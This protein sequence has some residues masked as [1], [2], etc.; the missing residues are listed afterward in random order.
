MFWFWIGLLLAI[1]LS[2]IANLLTPNVNRLLLRWNETRRAS[3]ERRAE[4]EQEEIARILSH[5]FR[6]YRYLLKLI[7]GHLVLLTLFFVLY[8]VLSTAPNLLLLAYR[9]TGTHADSKEIARFTDDFAQ[10]HA[11]VAYL[12]ALVFLLALTKSARVVSK[13]MH[14]ADR[15]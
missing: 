6:F 7:Y 14:D 12:F 13:L 4:E 5:P 11:V 1:P 10:L 9:I 8:W 2:I 15:P 3:Y